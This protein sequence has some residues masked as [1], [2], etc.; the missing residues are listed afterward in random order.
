MTEH[1]QEPDVVAPTSDW[2]A[3]AIKEQAR[4]LGFEL[5]GIAPVD[6]PL[7]EQGFADWL[8]AGYGG[9]M[10]YMAR[11]EQARRHPNTWMPWAR[12]VV[13]VAMR[14]ATPFPR[15]TRDTDVP[16]GWISR[17]AWGDDYHAMMEHRLES[18]LG[19]IRDTV[20]GEVQGKVYVRSEE[21]RVG[22]ECRSRWSPYH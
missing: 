7:H 12:S 6:D 2:L 21:R 19:W 10:A 1:S 18:L 22:K 5:V 11:T 17:Y 14:Y 16:R 20:G 13:S 15:E 9:E 4:S 8:Q 3:Q